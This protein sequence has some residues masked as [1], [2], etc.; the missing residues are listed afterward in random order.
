MGTEPLR[1]DYGYKPSDNVGAIEILLQA[2]ANPEARDEEGLT[3]LLLAARCGRPSRV[4]AL[5]RLNADIN[6]CDDAEKTAAE[7]VGSHH[8]AEQAAQIVR[9][10]SAA[11]K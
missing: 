2:G 8:D 5:L 7:Q 3:P 9:I 6:A 4:A 10:L 11:W 1:P